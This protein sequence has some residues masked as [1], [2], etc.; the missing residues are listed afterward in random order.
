MHRSS[1]RASL[2]AGLGIMIL[3]A[4]CGGGGAATPTPATAPTLGLPTSP[5]VTSPPV[6]TQG[7]TG[8]PAL[9]AAS[10]VQAGA[11]FDVAWAG[12]NALNDYV[13]VVKLGATAWTNEDYF[14]TSGGTPQ[15]LLA[16]NTPGDY[17]LWYVAG[18]SKEILAR[19]P[20][21]ILAFVG[22]LDAPPSVE[23]NKEFDVAWTGPNGPGDYV[24]IVKL[25]AEKWTNEKY[26]NTSGGTPQKL[27]API[28]AGSY[29]LWYV[30]GTEAVIQIRRPIA[31][32]ATSATL[33][34]P[35]EV[36]KAAQFQVTWTGPNGPGDYVTIVPVGSE[37]SAYLSYF[38]TNAGNPGT[39][40]APDATGD[41][42]IWYVSTQGPTVIKSIPIRVR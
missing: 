41:F 26:F 13:T 32:T 37:P 39:L 8:D 23:A 16:P 21:K 12:P 15:K 30:T 42:E 35:A 27:V 28:E 14:N 18:A 31:V 40:T 2:G 17:E 38:N 4:A 10:E 22:T 5:V 7:S 29:E 19:R 24:T 6:A 25:G 20:L 3:V 9:D 36:A 34:A 1:V 33:T 11:E